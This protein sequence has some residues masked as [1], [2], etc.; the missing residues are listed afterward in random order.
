MSSQKTHSTNINS[1]FISSVIAKKTGHPFRG[2]V[3]VVLDA[4]RAV[5]T[6]DWPSWLKQ[7]DGDIR[8][9]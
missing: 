1:A 6:M 4:D 5:T 3:C 9:R 7:T 2:A 8:P